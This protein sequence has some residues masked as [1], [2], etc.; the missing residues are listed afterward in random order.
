MKHLLLQ[1]L[2][3]GRLTDSRQRKV[4]FRNTVI[5]LT[6]NSTRIERDFAPELLN[7]FDK[8]ITYRKLTA[9]VS[10]R[11]VQKQLDEFNDRPTRT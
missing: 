10:L 3:E 11:L 7:R 8:I 4:Y 2:E 6:T 9:D 1:L 5:V